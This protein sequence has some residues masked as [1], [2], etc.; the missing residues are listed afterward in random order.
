MSSELERLTVSRGGSCIVKG[1]SGCNDLWATSCSDYLLSRVIINRKYKKTY[2]YCP[3]R[4]L[5]ELSQIIQQILVDNSLT[6]SSSS[7]AATASSEI[8]GDIKIVNNWKKFLDIIKESKKSTETESS[9]YF[10]YSLNDL[11][12]NYNIKNVM[13]D[14]ELIFSI[15]ESDTLSF[16]CTVLHTSLTSTP[17]IEM[18]SSL[19]PIH[20]NLTTGGILPDDV[21]A[22]VQVVRRSLTTGRINEGVEYMKWNKL[23]LE[24]FTK[25]IIVKD[26]KE[27]KKKD[28][29]SKNDKKNQVSTSSSTSESTSPSPDTTTSTDSIFSSIT[30]N[31]KKDVTQIL[32]EV[33]ETSST[34]SLSSAPQSRLI[35]FESTDPEFDEDSD[36]DADLDL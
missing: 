9:A 16:F 2:I 7:S 12:L 30:S 6:S 21:L 20:V 3:E 17:I 23:V 25:K 15:L 22:E 29:K 31:S 32:A 11:L 5:R 33:Q 10:I 35:T 36:P 34:S 14:Y 28:K 18:F 1:S 26:N 4:N 19:F 27:D 13:K 8:I 24:P